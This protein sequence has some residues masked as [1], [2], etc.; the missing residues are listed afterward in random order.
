M[1]NLAVVDDP[2]PTNLEVTVTVTEQGITTSPATLSVPNGFDGTIT[3]TIS[4]TSNASF[5]EPA[6]T[7]GGQYP[8]SFELTNQNTPTQRVRRWGNFLEQN[9]QQNAL[10]L[11]YYYTIHAVVNGTVI[12]HDPTVE[13]L[14]PGT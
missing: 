6:I 4:S 5:L 13:N 2:L 9:A 11:S 3:W 12:K 10:P 14:P 8:P 7:F 1:S